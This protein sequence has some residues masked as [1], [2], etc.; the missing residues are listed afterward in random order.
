MFLVTSVMLV[1]A[2]F[3]AYRAWRYGVGSR[4][5]FAALP[6]GLLFASAFVIP[7]VVG[8]L[9]RVGVEAHFAGHG[10]DELVSRPTTKQAHE[11]EH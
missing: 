11:T 9:R 1:F 2:G 8:M 5:Y 10:S 4:R 3:G 7:L 6:I